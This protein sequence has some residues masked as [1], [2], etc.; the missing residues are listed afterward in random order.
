MTLRVV[1]LIQNS[2]IHQLMFCEQLWLL[3][4]I[5]NSHLDHEVFDP[6]RSLNL[7]KVELCLQSVIHLVVW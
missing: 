5:K 1:N 7:I 4:I 6:V 2:L 3:R